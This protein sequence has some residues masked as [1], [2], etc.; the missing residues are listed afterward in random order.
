MPPTRPGAQ[1]GAST[2]QPSAGTGL[3][4][5]PALSAN[6]ADDTEALAAVPSSFEAALKELEM[7]VARMESGELTLEESLSAYQ[8][9]AQLLQYCQVKLTDAQQQVKLLE[10]GVLKEFSGLGENGQ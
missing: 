8:R 6:A 3:P 5:V 10:A 2:A 7:V 4:D 1:K 9:G